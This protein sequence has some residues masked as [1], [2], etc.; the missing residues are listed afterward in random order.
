MH[1]AAL[2]V[3][4]AE[5]PFQLQLGGVDADDGAGGVGAA[6]REGRPDVGAVVV[7]PAVVVLYAS[8]PFSVIWREGV[9]RCRPL[10]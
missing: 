9:P 10:W 5:Q 8:V 2:V 3:C 6:L 1:D 4:H 7:Y